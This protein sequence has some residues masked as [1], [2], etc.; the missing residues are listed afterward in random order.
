MKEMALPWAR[1]QVQTSFGEGKFL[2]LFLHILSW[3]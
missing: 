1:F 2:A 3:S